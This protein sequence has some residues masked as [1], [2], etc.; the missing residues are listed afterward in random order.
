MINKGREKDYGFDEAF[1][2]LENR[3]ELFEKLDHLTAPKSVIDKSA[4]LIQKALDSLE[5]I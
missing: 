3:V 5:T 2:H 1:A 4:E